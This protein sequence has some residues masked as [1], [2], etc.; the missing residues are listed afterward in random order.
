MTIAFD[1][2]LLVCTLEPGVSSRK[3]RADELLVRSLRNG[4]DVFLLQALTEFANVAVRKLGLPAD[5]I[6]RRVDAWQSALPVRSA[7][8]EDALAALDA[9]RDHRLLFWDAML[10][11]TARRVGVSALLTE[12]LQDGRTLQGVRFVNPFNPKNDAVVD[13]LLPP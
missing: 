11:A 7:E 13:R 4:T 6:R 9:V 1:S 12:D 3:G 8:T 10:W 5:A 2:N